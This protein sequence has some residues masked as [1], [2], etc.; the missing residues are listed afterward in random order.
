MHLKISSQ[1][2][3]IFEWIPYN[4]FDNIKKIG[5]GGFATLYSTIWKK[6]PLYYNYNKEGYI[7]L[8]DQKVALKLLH[9]SQNIDDEFLNEV[10]V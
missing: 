5:E 4:Q 10:W 6:G 1:N 3:I 9:N 8:S 2:N 7:R